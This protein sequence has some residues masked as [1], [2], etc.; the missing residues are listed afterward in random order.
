MWLREYEQDGDRYKGRDSTKK[1]NRA[2][3][4]QRMRDKLPDM[5][6]NLRKTISQWEQARP[7]NLVLFDVLLGRTQSFR[8]RESGLQRRP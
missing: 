2:L 7:L 8:L 5:I 3:R 6:R 4:A 1:L